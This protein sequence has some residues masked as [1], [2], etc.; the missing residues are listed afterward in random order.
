MGGVPLHCSTM[1]GKNSERL[2]RGGSSADMEEKLLLPAPS[3]LDKGRRWR[4]EKPGGW[5]ERSGG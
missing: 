3:E 4:G 5:W 1:G 2:S